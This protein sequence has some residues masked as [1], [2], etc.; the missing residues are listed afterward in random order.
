[1][2][3]IFFIFL[4]SFIGNFKSEA[5]YNDFEKQNVIVSLG[6]APSKIIKYTGFG[7]DFYNGID[8]KIFYQA[9]NSL[10]RYGIGLQYLLRGSRYTYQQYLFGNQT[11]KLVAYKMHSISLPLYTKKALFKSFS[12]KLTLAPTYILKATGTGLNDF[13]ET[14]DEFIVRSKNLLKTKEDHFGSTDP[15]NQFNV[16][17]SFA[18][19]KKINFNNKT[20]EVGLEY[21]R[22]FF[23][24]INL[25]RD[26]KLPVDKLHWLSLNVARI[27]D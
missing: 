12:V 11:H 16:Y 7:T 4:F 10:F 17:G 22:D 23:D 19:S 27:I 2:K 9:N 6:Y 26:Y 14:Q 13:E 20:F 5:Q 15:I 21:A 3:Y 1:M 8:I 25:E 18:L 24:T